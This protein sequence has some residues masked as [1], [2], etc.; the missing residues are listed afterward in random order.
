MNIRRELI[1]HKLRE[2]SDNVNKISENMPSEFED[3]V[4]MELSK[5][6]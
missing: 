1:E 2:I 6:S 5:G 4:G 3:F